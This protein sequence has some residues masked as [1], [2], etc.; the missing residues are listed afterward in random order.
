MLEW[1][2]QAQEV[3]LDMTWTNL[4]ILTQVEIL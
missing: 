4:G 1:L 3:E 2:L